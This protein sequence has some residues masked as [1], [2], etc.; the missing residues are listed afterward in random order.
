MNYNLDQNAAKQADNI[1]ARIEQKGRYL[2]M[3]T[4]AESIKSEK[5][6]QG[7]DL[8][9]KSDNG[10]SADYLTLW[11]H[12]KDG[13][14]LM[15]FNMLMAIMTCLR[16]KSLNAE[17]GEIEKYIQE[18]KKREKVSANLYK[19][20]MN[21]PIT[22]LMYMEE[23]AKNAGGTAWKPVIF[24]VC[25]KDGFTA[26]E[27]FAKNTT[28]NTVEKMVAALKDRPL[29]TATTTAPRQ[30]SENPGHGMEDDGY[31]F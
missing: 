6:T 29:K 25:D 15:G 26:S 10:E 4:R 22:L 18:T 3:I 19:E 14:Q 31:P 2:G 21:K 28:A 11:T 17:A 16:V 9:F 20:L 1:N 7:V 24:S 27:I 8:S 23:Y 5:G 12:N 13:K 30:D